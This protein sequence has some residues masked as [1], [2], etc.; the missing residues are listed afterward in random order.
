MTKLTIFPDLLT[1][2]VFFFSGSVRK[3]AKQK[4]KPEARL[5]ER[6]SFLGDH[7]NFF[8]IQQLFVVLSHME[9]FY[10]CVGFT[11]CGRSVTNTR[12]I[13]IFLNKAGGWLC[14]ISMN[15]WTPQIVAGGDPR[16]TS[17]CQ[18]NPLGKKTTWTTSYGVWW[19]WSSSCL[20]TV[21]HHLKND[22]EPSFFWKRKNVIDSKNSTIVLLP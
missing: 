3:R 22:F 5:E 2:E 1:F 18:L 9:W 19:F 4:T 10:I 14:S 6:I 21:W 7:G 8:S 17:C 20:K 11:A 12:C 15:I 13:R 16:K